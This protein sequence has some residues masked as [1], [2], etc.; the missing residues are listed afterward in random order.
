[1]LNAKKE[2]VLLLGTDQRITSGPRNTPNPGADSA[3]VACGIITILFAAID[4]YINVFHEQTRITS[5]GRTQGSLGAEF[6]SSSRLFDKYNDDI[7]QKL[8]DEFD[9]GVDDLVSVSPAIWRLVYMRKCQLPGII[10]PPTFACSRLKR[11]LS[12]A[13]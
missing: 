11:A 1:L 12:E 5:H 3:V 13:N 4:T 2:R 6:Y 7:E 9:N 10:Q 8:K